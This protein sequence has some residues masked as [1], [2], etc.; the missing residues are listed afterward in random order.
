MGCNDVDFEICE[1]GST[2]TQETGEEFAHG[3]FT[4]GIHGYF[5]LYESGM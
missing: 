3:E 2:G 5:V 4:V 1:S